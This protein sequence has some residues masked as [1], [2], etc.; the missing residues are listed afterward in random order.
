M[1][2]L[3]ET[4]INK[5]KQ[6]NKISLFFHEIPDFDALGA[7]FALKKF[8]HDIYPEKE[9]N[10]IGLD[11]LDESF[12]KNFFTFP[13]E[14][15]PNS[16][17]SE[18][19]GIILD[20]ANEARIWSRRHRYCKELIRIDHHPQVESI[21]QIEWIDPNYPATCEMVGDLLFKWDQKYILAPTAQMLYAGI[22]TDTN[23]FLYM[24]TRPNTFAL[25]AKLLTI[26]F[27]RQRINDAI[28]LKSWVEA[29]FDSY[30]MNRVKLVKNLKFAYVILAKNSFDKY[31]V[32]LRMSMVHVLNNIKDLEIWM[33]IYY[34]DSV[35]AWRGS[36]RS[37]TL[38]INQIAEKYNGGGHKNAAGFTLKN[39]GQ[40][41]KLINDICNYLSSI[42]IKESEE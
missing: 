1:D 31:H 34:D 35:K 24:N 12:A 11:I 38:P 6:Y 14:H 20:T 7:C 3:Q 5:I 40:A 16:F 23:R 26:Q 41:K 13:K 37:R 36:I 8:I 39:Y 17:L 10:I 9:V 32:E 42:Q 29:R 25:A 27:N 19:L 28:Y 21:A 30:V 18:S 2:F 33:A 15:V 22:V 4:I